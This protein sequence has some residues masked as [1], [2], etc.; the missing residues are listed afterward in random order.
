MAKINSMTPEQMQAMIA[1]REEWVR[2]GE[3]T[4]RNDPAQ[5][6]EAVASVY[7]TANLSVPSVIVMDSPLGCLIARAI[8]MNMANLWDNLGDNLREN[9]TYDY[10]SLWGQHDVGWLAFYD[11]PQALGHKYPTELADR[12]AAAIRYAKLSGWLYAYKR[13]AFVS[14]KQS[15]LHRDHTGRLHNAGGMAMAFADGYGFHAWHG[16]RVPAWCIENKDRIT[17]ETILAEANTEVRR[18]M[19]EIIGWPRTMDLLG[20]K[21]IHA[22]E[23]LGLPRKLIEIDLNGSRVRLL[24]M[25]NGTVENGAR[26]EFIEGVPST[27]GTC[28]EAVA[29]QCGVPARIHNECV[30]T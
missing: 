8:V 29:W 2:N 17:K 13:F 5:I 28:H 16:I 7:A 3:S 15:Q 24:H 11:F 27:I 14:Q 30:R 21:Q 9:K 25:T 18:A 12:L 19:C 26:R 22:D 10:A 6:R 23:C 1:Y 4:E 20:G